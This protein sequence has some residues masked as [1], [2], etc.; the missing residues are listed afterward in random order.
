[1]EESS[2]LATVVLPISLAV[3]M[4]SLGLSLTLADF[5]RVVTFPR[6]AALG[7]TNLLLISPFLGF[8]VAEA[9]NLDPLLAVGLVLMARRRVGRSPTCSPIWP[10][11]TPRCR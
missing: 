10:V 8:V 6:G 7:V 4:C 2:F 11:A 1:M 9:F 5:K 3:I